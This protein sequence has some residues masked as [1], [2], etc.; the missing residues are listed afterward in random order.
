MLF[1]ALKGQSN[2]SQVIE[3]TLT[4]NVLKLS[5]EHLPKQIQR[6]GCTKSKFSLKC[7]IIPSAVSRATI[8][9]GISAA[10]F[11]TIYN[12]YCVYCCVKPSFI[13]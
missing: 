7:R 5:L 12:F 6:G 8:H 1:F 3:N 4:R 9:V 2:K 13:F 11:T 10:V